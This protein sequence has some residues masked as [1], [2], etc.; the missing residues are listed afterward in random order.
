MHELTATARGVCPPARSSSARS[1]PALPAPALSSAV[2]PAV[3]VVAVLLLTL[4]TAGLTAGGAAA[5]PAVPTHYRSTVTAVETADGDPVDL[6]VEVLGGDAYLA[7]SVPAGRTLEVPGYQ[8][9]PYIRVRADGVVEVNDRSPARWLND[10]RYGEADPDVELPSSAD[11]DAPPSWEPVAREGTYAWHDHRIH[12]MSPGLPSQVDPGRDEVQRVWEWEVPVVLDD[13]EVVIAGTLDWVP[14]PGPAVPVVAIVLVAAAGVLL[15]RRGTWVAET[16]VLVAAVLGLVPGVAM[17]VGQPPGTE[18]QPALLVLP[19]V[20]VAALLLARWLR[21]R[22]DPR[23][24]W[25]LALAPVP[26]LVVGGL[27]A[28]AVT[29]PFVPGAL[30]AAAVRATLV[31]MVGAGLAV[32]VT[33][34]RELAARLSLDAGDADPPGADER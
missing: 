27:L 7:V 9:E 29:R 33:L 4:L 18:G 10:A 28:G 8:G 22:S 20:A 13:D 23:A 11:A 14:G 2:R 3:R 34:A 24:P 31:V 1:S 21:A 5:D 25:L 16:V 15:A 32:L 12:F 26:L 30:P 19:I 6:D 17:N